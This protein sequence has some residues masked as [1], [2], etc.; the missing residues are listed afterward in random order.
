MLNTDYAEGH[1]GGDF[2]QILTPLPRFSSDNVV[3]V[4]VGGRWEFEAI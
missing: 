2:P 3:V 4:N 1:E